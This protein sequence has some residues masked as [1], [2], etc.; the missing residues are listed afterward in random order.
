MKTTT[1]LLT[2][3]AVLALTTACAADPTLP[4]P[5]NAG[6]GQHGN[7]VY[8]DHRYPADPYPNRADPYDYGRDRAPTDPYYDQNRYAE[9]YWD[10]RAQRH[11]YVDDRTGSTYWHNGELR[12]R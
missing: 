8:A 12:S 2:A 7:D 4:R 10:E 9:R 11:F 5:A 6:Y 3:G 1:K